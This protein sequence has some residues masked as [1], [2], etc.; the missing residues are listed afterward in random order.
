MESRRAIWSQIA[1]EHANER[2]RVLENEIRKAVREDKALLVFRQRQDLIPSLQLY[3]LLEKRAS[4][5]VG[6]AYEICRST[7]KEQ[8]REQTLG[9]RARGEQAAGGRS[10]RQ[11]HNHCFNK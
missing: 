8:S 7:W 1:V 4:D 10:R 2:L 9:Q 3:S 5:W 11:H 6:S